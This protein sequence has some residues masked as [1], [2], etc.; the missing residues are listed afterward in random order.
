[1][2]DTSQTEATKPSP[3]P[4]APESAAAAST[5]ITGPEELLLAARKEAAAS[6]DRSSYP[7]GAGRQMAAM[8]A[9]GARTEALQALDVPTL[10]IHGRDDELITPSAGF[11]T[12]E[13]IPGSTLLFVSDA[14]KRAEKAA[15][16]LKRDGADRI[17]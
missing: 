15:K 1:M 7:E 4:A 14:R 5:A 16:E 10:V 9:S 6:Y 13:L 17:S 3:A 2:S 11:R 8:Y 12:A